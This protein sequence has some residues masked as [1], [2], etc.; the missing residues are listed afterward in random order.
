MATSEALLIAVKSL[1]QKLNH[2]CLV[3]KIERSD[4]ITKEIDLLINA[5][6][7]ILNLLKTL[8]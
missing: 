5:K 6:H 7:T 1:E 4:N 2:L 3:T 8:N